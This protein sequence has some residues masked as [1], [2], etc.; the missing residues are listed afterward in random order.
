[1]L[2]DFRSKIATS[3]VKSPKTKPQNYSVEKR[4]KS[5]DF[6][7][8]ILK[9]NNSNNEKNKLEK[10]I[11]FSPISSSN[12]KVLNTSK[13]NNFVKITQY[14][15][16]AYE[17]KNESLSKERDRSKKGSG[18]YTASILA[19]ESNALARNIKKNDTKDQTQINNT[20]YS[21]VLTENCFSAKSRI[22]KNKTLQSDAKRPQK[23]EI[24]RNFSPKNYLQSSKHTESSKKSIFD[25]KLKPTTIKLAKGSGSSQSPMK[26]MKKESSMSQ[27]SNCFK[28]E[29]F[30]EIK[31]KILK[32]C[33]SNNMTINE[34]ILRN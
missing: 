28:I 19:T 10:P 22:T 12:G 5:A 24:L 4:K 29:K 34:V 8:K 21:S 33:K 31:S 18:N 13:N 11:T 25:Y 3:N 1:M 20:N 7:S 14:T 17:N 6:G 2:K 32:F 16:K 23:E 26:R 30:D 27:E 15:T 9:G